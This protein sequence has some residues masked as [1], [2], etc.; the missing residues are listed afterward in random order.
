[1][2]TDYLLIASRRA[3]K[4]RD[5]TGLQKSPLGLEGGPPTPPPQTVNFSS[6]S[7]TPMEHNFCEAIYSSFFPYFYLLSAAHADKLCR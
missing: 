6:H 7:K 5:K 4:S 1:M 2:V 3:N